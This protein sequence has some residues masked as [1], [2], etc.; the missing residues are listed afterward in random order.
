MFCFA[1]N[2]HFV[3]T[4]WPTVQLLEQHTMNLIS[5]P[6]KCYIW[7]QTLC[8]FFLNYYYFFSY[9][10][11][12]SHPQWGPTFPCPDNMPQSSHSPLPSSCLSPKTQM[13]NPYFWTFCICSGC[14]I[15]MSYFNH[16]LT[17]FTN[18]KAVNKTAIYSFQISH[19]QSRHYNPSKY[20]SC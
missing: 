17:Q 4:S 3:G 12:S 15:F 5:L 1:L 2:Q 20:F 7:K 8:P 16:L 6:F 13:W 10:Q 18:F 14:L 11:S 9:P 19:P